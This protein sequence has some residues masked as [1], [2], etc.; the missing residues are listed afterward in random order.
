MARCWI[1][2][3]CSI[4]AARLRTATVDVAVASTALHLAEKNRAR[5]QALHDAEII[6]G[7]ELS[8]VAAQWQSDR[9][10]EEAAR[11]HVE[12][13]HR[14]ARHLW[15]DEL[16]HLAL[17]RHA[18]LLD[19]LANH[20]RV[21]LQIT[22]PSGVSLPGQDATL[23]VARDFDRAKAIRA[24]LISA[25]PRTDDLVQ[26]ETWFFHAAAEYLRAGM[27][28]NA[29]VPRAGKCH[30]LAL[31]VSAIVWHAGRSWVYRE[32]GEGSYTRLPVAGPLTG[33]PQLFIDTC[34]AP[35]M[36]VAVTGAQTLLS[37]EFRGH[38]PS[39]DDV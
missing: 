36:R 7:R 33:D 27:R 16:A 39:D 35:G 38:I 24:E 9:T 32:D 28:V 4:S 3:P 8:Q 13:I 31:P 29:W 17:D 12:E 23:F 25:A 2:Q 10:R 26:G 15:G 6:A 18:Q 14:E 5:I 1:S 30:G 11:R 22:L 20:R 34:L 21:L 37:E 19:G